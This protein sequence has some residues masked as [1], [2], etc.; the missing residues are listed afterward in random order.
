[1]TILFPKFPETINLPVA[2]TTPSLRAMKKEKTIECLKIIASDN[3]ENLNSFF[4][5]NQQIFSKDEMYLF[6]DKA[7]DFGSLKIMDRLLLEKPNIR[8]KSLF[9]ER[10]AKEGYVKGVVYASHLSIEASTVFDWNRVL[11]VFAS[12]K[13]S[14]LLSDLLFSQ[15]KEVPK[16][17][18]SGA[19]AFGQ[20]KDKNYLSFET[21]SKILNVFLENPGKFRSFLS[22]STKDTVK[23]SLLEHFLKQFAY[24]ADH[25]SVCLLADIVK[26]NSDV[27][28]ATQLFMQTRG[29]VQTKS[30]GKIF[31][32]TCDSFS[33]YVLLKSKNLMKDI[34][35][36]GQAESLRGLTAKENFWQTALLSSF[37]AYPALYLCVDL[38]LQEFL[39]E[40]GNTPA[41][42][43]MTAKPG[44]ETVILAKNLHKEWI[45][46][47]NNAGE[48]LSSY[49]T[50]ET[51]KVHI[52]KYVLGVASERS[53]HKEN[54]KRKM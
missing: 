7:L 3:E 30:K 54:A 35:A 43:A 16:F 48:I 1:M 23:N 44:R 53:H 42:L 37:T 2:A 18:I 11:D 21:A 26:K 40:E 27:S 14:D 29:V 17:Y 24:S 50:N 31:L 5:Q 51:T 49:A 22:Y 6:L 4:D 12:Q 41:H 32:Y 47:E 34:V 8:D 10:C 15:D 28:S 38:G 13:R 39:D 19:R 52:Q 20:P 33:E 36:G 25:K 9:A 45:L 46:K